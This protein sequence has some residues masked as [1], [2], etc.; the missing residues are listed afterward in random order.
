MTSLSLK[1]VS[2]LNPPQS[3]FTKGGGSVSPLS[4][5]GARGDFGTH[6]VIY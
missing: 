6:Y 5:R 1:R 4:Q 3:P 2:P